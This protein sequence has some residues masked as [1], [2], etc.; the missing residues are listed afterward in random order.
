MPPTAHSFDTLLDIIRADFR[1]TPGMCLTRDQFRRL[2]H[3]D[4]EQC[5][6]LT[7]RLL[8]EGYLERDDLQRLH[9]PMTTQ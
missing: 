1:E 8:Q 5:D 3:L 7:G 6:A 2:W 9:R 4:Q